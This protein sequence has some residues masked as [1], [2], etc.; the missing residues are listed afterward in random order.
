MRTPP[1]DLTILGLI[2]FL[3]ALT[4]LLSACGPAGAAKITGPPAADAR[5]RSL[6]LRSVVPMGADGPVDVVVDDGLVTAVVPSGEAEAGA[7][8]VV[9]GDG[10][11]VLPGFVDSHVHLLYLPEAGAMGD[12]GIA[13]AVDL[14]APMAFFSTD[15]GDVRVV[16]SGPMVT[17]PG[18]YPTRG[19]GAAG[20]GLECANADEA[21]AAVES[22]AEAGAV[23]VK[24][25]ITGSPG[26]SETALRAAAARA[27]ELGLRVA[28]HALG[29]D[30]ALLAAAIGADV[31]AHTPTEPLSDEALEAWSD[32]AVV[33]TLRAFG[34]SAAAVDN[35]RRLREAGAVV[36]YGTD[37]G[38]T[39]TAGI[40]RAEL[41][42]LG[43]A[44]LDAEAIVAAGTTAPAEWWGLDGL[45]A[46][47]VGAE[48]SFLL[49]DR[50]PTADPRD[51]ASPDVVVLRG[52]VR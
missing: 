52:V 34:G 49:Y 8:T 45:G 22:L 41:E 30:Q 17:G 25:P 24:L 18:G 7:R 1:Q 31:L 33:S 2:V 15:F 9:P 3:G 36:L 26:L 11:V 48:A 4:L 27:H 32:R 19:W 40:D 23:V 50:D 21:V 37:F 35:L 6:L 47:E 10:R 43:H 38:N 28:T 14:A 51:L 44:G 12:G 46:I 42:L 5:A 16:G 29:S 39:R 13:A 20:Y